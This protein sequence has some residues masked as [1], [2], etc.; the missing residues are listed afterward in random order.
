MT[1]NQIGYDRA[2]YSRRSDDPWRIPW[3]N[4]SHLT[5]GGDQAVPGKGAIHLKPWKATSPL[6]LQGS[7]TSMATTDEILSMAGECSRS[8]SKAQQKAMI[9]NSRAR[10]DAAGQERRNWAMEVYQGNRGRDPLEEVEEDILE[11][12]LDAGGE[13]FDR[14]HLVIEIFYS[15]KSFNPQYP[16][17]EMMSVWGILNLAS[18]KK[19]GDY[20]FKLE[21]HKEEKELVIEGGPW[22]HKG[23]ALIIMHYDGYSRPLEIRVE[24]IGLWIRQYDLPLVM[25]KEPVAKM[26]GRQIGTF[27]KMDSSYPGYM[28][29]RVDFPLNKALV[30]QLTVRIKGRGLMGITVRYENVPHFCFS[31]GHIG[32]A[33][34]NCKEAEE[35]LS[36]KFGEELRVS[37]PR[38][39][40]NIIIRD[41]VPRVA[42]PLFQAGGQRTASSRASY[43]GRQP[44]GHVTNDNPGRDEQVPPEDRIPPGLHQGG[45]NIDNAGKS[46]L[47][48]QT[49]RH[50]CGK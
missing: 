13:E 15:R 48:V 4:I 17:S 26:L 45:S 37:P 5:G 29:V 38:R 25:M 20:I 22:R 6:G 41:T 40:R 19:I 18:L 9:P 43:G 16:F 28:R 36:I 8:M 14:K 1:R 27:I 39:S 42:R 7:S 10:S 23:E 33:A 49:L 46:A 32:H 12:D 34:M 31:C 44:T 50:A 35:D 3:R 11:L 24:S 30:P 47:G 21:F 2:T